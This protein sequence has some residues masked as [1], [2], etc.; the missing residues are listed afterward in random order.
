MAEL[1]T[2]DR[3]WHRITALVK[4]RPSRCQVAVAY[5]GTGASK[6]L[7]LRKG[8]TLVVDLSKRAVGTGQTKPSEVLKLVNKGVDASAE[9]AVAPARLEVH[10]RLA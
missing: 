8:S 3:A 1:V 5:F 9:D 7:P 10:P 2:H 6:L 4:R